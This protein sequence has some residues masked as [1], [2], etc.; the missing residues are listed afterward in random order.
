MTLNLRA[1]GVRAIL[2]DIEGTTTP[3]TF[4]YDVLFPYAR[5]RLLTYLD[6]HRDSDRVGDV[7]RRLV[8]EWARDHARG[9]EWAR[10]HARGESPPEWREATVDE[11]L[12]S[13]ADYAA[14]LMQRDRKSP[15]LK[16]L[17]GFI[18]EEGYR[19]GDLH[20]EVFD[21]VPAALARWHA[22]GLTLA[23]YSSG[24]VLAQRLLF[25]ATAHGDLTPLFSGFFDT[26]VGA[27]TERASY[28][29]IAAELRQRPEAI[30]FISDVVAELA[31]ARAA[32]CQVAL[33]M[34]P[35]NAEQP[36]DPAPIVRNFDEIQP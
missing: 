14:W 30:L 20:G 32:G 16:L 9:D 2:L 24:S 28:A 27:K 29:R 19:A 33:S 15:G 26:S 36:A 25:G 6:Q 12:H 1:L 7:T 21:D 5:A 13:A 23:I 18:W 4:V 10:D 3:V 31:A 11:R 8:D 34:R 35:G 17:Q 22:A